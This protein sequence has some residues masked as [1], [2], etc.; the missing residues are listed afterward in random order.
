MPSSNWD[1]TLPSCHVD[2]AYINS[3][4][5]L[6]VAHSGGR[7]LAKPWPHPNKRGLFSKDDFKLDLKS[8][9]ITCPAG[10]VEHF[11]LASTVNF[12]PE[13]CGGCRL[14]AQCTQAASGRGR[15]VQIAEDEA[16]QKKFRRLQQTRP[17][18]ALLRERTAVEHSLAHI[19]SRKGATARYI[20]VRKNLFDLRRAATIQNLEGLQ[21]LLAA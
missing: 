12:D 19:A 9:T 18:R 17:G 5:V 20:G 13:V 2:R 11:E 4:V 16:R 6:E 3:P 8:Q 14:R 15:T 10:Q 21:R 1:W 7:V